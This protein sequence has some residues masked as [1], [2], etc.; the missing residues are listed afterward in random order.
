MRLEGRGAVI[1][2]ITNVDNSIL[3]NDYV[4]VWDQDGIPIHINRKALDF[5][6]NA[7][8]GNVRPVQSQNSVQQDISN[9]FL[10]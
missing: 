8:Y 6:C 10:K 7:V 5:V 9:A 4:V 1:D 3:G 2:N